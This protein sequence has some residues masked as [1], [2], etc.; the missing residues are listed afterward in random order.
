MPQLVGQDKRVAY[1][2]NGRDGHDGLR[3]RGHDASIGGDHASG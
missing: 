2:K 3:E 1:E